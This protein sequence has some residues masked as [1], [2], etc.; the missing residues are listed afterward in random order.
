MDSSW[1]THDVR[2]TLPYKAS[3]KIEEKS[4][5]SLAPSTISH[6][7]GAASW[8]NHWL[9]RPE[10]QHT[11][12]RLLLIYQIFTQL[13]VICQSFPLMDESASDQVQPDGRIGTST[14]ND[15]PEE[16]FQG[17]TAV[18]LDHYYAL[19][20]NHL[21]QSPL[22]LDFSCLTRSIEPTELPPGSE[23]EETTSSPSEMHLPHGDEDTLGHVAA[24]E[25]LNT[26]PP[27]ASN[28]HSP[29]F[30]DDLFEVEVEKALQPMDLSKTRRVLG[31][32]ALESNQ[33]RQSSNTTQPAASN[34]DSR[35]DSDWAN[36]D[37]AEWD[38][39]TK[40]K[41]AR[42][43]SKAPTA[44]DLQRTPRVR[45]NSTTV[46]RPFKHVPP[47]PQPHVRTLW[48]AHNDSF[49]TT[50]KNARSQQSARRASKRNV[51]ATGT[52]LNATKPA[53]ETST[54]PEHD[55]NDWLDDGH[56]DLALLINKPTG[57]SLERS[58]LDKINI[59]LNL[60]K[61][62]SKRMSEQLDQHLASIVKVTD[63]QLK[64]AAHE[65]FIN[66]STVKTHYNRLPDLL[67]EIKSILS[68]TEI[69]TPVKQQQLDLQWPKV[70]TPRSKPTTPSK[71]TD[72]YNGGIYFLDLEPKKRTG[73]NPEEVFN[74]ATRE[75]VMHVDNMAS[76][77]LKARVTFRSKIHR[78]NAVKAL[79]EHYFKGQRVKDLF[80]LTLDARSEFVFVT[81]PINRG[82]FLTLDL[83]EKGLLIPAKAIKD[84][85]SR[86][87]D[88]FDSTDDIINVKAS[89]PQDENSG[90]IITLFVSREAAKKIRESIKLG[91]R[92][93]LI[94]K[95]VH[96]H[97]PYQVDTCFKCHSPAHYSYSCDSP[98]RCKYCPGIHKK[99]R[100]C[101]QPRENPICFR[102][103]EYNLTIPDD[104]LCPPKGV[105]HTASSALCP[106]TRHLRKRPTTS[107]EDEPANK[108]QSS[109]Y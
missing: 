42:G 6:R 36:F 39:A 31:E 1:F 14:S 20:L 13:S 51:K 97:E 105:R 76:S 69:T 43:K 72:D 48:P 75:V 67:E 30:N 66:N 103:Y 8:P 89:P 60:A 26:P 28:V 9:A 5:E 54:S 78:E 18:A 107:V 47:A 15:A 34:Y 83:Q 10:S 68:R 58:A 101:K 87:P 17:E 109:R 88:W 11:S 41:E 53:N 24:E 33:S 55:G 65:R 7:C 96:I 12:D 108:R 70:R 46:S 25:V 93:D 100:D 21:G 84:M 32:K 91:V 74:D 73:F 44:T 90:Y 106:S 50:T 79:S 27:P 23:E 4:R 92:L 102:C 63:T 98:I 2:T 35:V 29:L 86:N 62:I 80:N 52:A 45:D 71:S 99:A 38:R 37:P 95:Q 77:G 94:K 85:T 64:V 57:E 82:K 22:N 61:G 81:S 49:S 16:P 56:C 40:P 19:P 3:K 59:I 104:S